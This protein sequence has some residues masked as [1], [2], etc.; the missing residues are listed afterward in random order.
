[1]KHILALMTAFLLTG[2]LSAQ[3]Y[4]LGIFGGISFYEG[5]MAPQ[6]TLD[7][8]ETLSPAFGFFGRAHVNDLIAF[9]AGYNRLRIFGNDELGGDPLGLAFE[10]DINELYARMELT[11]FYI[12]LFRNSASIAPFLFGGGSFFT[13]NPTREW[14]GQTVQLQP[15]GTEAQ[16]QPG[17]AAPY[18]LQGFA[19][20]FGGGI[21]WLLD[22]QWTLGIEFGGRKTFT[23][24]LDDTS[25]LSVTYGDVLQNG[26]LAAEISYPNL[27][28]DTADPNMSYKRGGPKPDWFFAGGLTLSYIF[29]YGNQRS[30]SGGG[31]KIK[32]YTF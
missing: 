22:D 16:G 5:E 32:C 4:E 24:Y 27:D 17:Y 29:G 11:P 9:K 8:V 28:Q 15:L 7:Y 14:N 3:N 21:K 30:G 25:A 1:M 31:K 19:I 18:D 6:E 26:A 20:H 23:D 12:P 2:E 10:S 13:F